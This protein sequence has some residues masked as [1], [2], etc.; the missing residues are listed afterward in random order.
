MKEILKNKLFLAVILVVILTVIMQVI[1]IVVESNVKEESIVVMKGY[2]SLTY[3]EN[4]GGAF[5]IG[6]EDTLSFVLVSLI[7]LG[8]IVHFLVSQRDKIDNKTM[9]ALS[10]M[11]AGGWSNLIDR[12]VRGA[13]IDYIDM[14]EYIKFPVFNIADSFIVI[15]WV[16]LVVSII[17]YWRNG[18]EKEKGK[19]TT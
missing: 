13:V 19:S 1:T 8:I 6:Q 4:T 11:L 2:I 9:L 12:L 18:N 10:F 17:R 15:G 14:T 5:G 7:V 16:L 3:V